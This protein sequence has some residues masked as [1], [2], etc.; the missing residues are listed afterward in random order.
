MADHGLVHSGQ[1]FQRLFHAGF[2]VAAHH[3]FNMQGLFHGIVLLDNGSR[4]GFGSIFSRC[5][6]HG[7]SGQGGRLGFAVV[8]GAVQVEQVQPQGIA[9]D[10]EAGK[11]HGRSPEHGVQGQAEG[12]EHTGGQR[13]ADDVVDERPEQV[14]VDVA[15]GGAAQP[16][17][18]GHIGEP[19]VHQD[20]IGCVNG[21]I[22]TGTDGDAGVR[23]G[24]GGGI[25]DAVAHHGH[26]AAFLQPADHGLLAV[27]QN[28]CN[29]LVHARLSANGIGG[30]LVVAGQHDHPDAHVLQLPDGAGAVLLE[31][32]RHGDHAHQAAC[33]AKEEGR[34][35]LSGQPGGFGLEFGGYGCLG[36]DELRI[37]AVDLHAVQPCGKAIAGQGGKIG[38]IGAGD[39]LCLGIGQHRLGQRVL[40]LLLQ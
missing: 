7:G 33:T 38:H 35:A 9:H 16:N 40:T 31:G 14:F 18:G 36:G 19:G 4:N 6:L 17:G 26:L 24:Q 15:Q 32:V 8:F 5:R 39:G 34:F 20:H 37:A 11:A 1:G 13:D 28:A 12:D 27:G 21:N 2:A 3:T 25:V 22:G 29:D 23:A 30:A 10:T